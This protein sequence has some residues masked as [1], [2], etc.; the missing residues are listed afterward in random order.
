MFL[1]SDTKFFVEE[2]KKELGED[3]SLHEISSI[4]K[5]SSNDDVLLLIDGIYHLTYSSNNK[6]GYPT[7]L[8]FTDV[9]LYMFIW[10]M[11]ILKIINNYWISTNYE[12]TIYEEA[13]YD[14]TLFKV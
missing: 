10:K 2:L 4:A 12:I 13:S 11:S 6:D 8:E 14:K 7:S 9:I 3:N 1:Q 5:S